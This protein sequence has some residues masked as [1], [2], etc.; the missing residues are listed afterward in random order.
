MQY[1]NKM[2]LPG[3]ICSMC[4][5]KVLSPCRLQLNSNITGD[6]T[7]YTSIPYDPACNGNDYAR[8]IATPDI[9]MASL[10]L[11]PTVAPYWTQF[12]QQQVSHTRWLS[13]HATAMQASL[14]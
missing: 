7:P 11:Y 10:H 2:T 1:H 13:H 6:Y 5:I 4:L 12:L 8:N 3:L 9:D 14:V